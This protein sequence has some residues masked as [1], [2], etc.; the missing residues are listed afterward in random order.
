MADLFNK[1]FLGTL[2]K[3]ER[4]TPK[5]PNALYMINDG[6]TGVKSMY[7]GTQ[8]VSGDFII[9]ETAPTPT[10]TEKGVIY[11]IANFGV[12]Q[13][14]YVGF[15]DGN[16][17]VALSD[18]ATIAAIETRIIDLEN[19]TK[20][21]GTATTDSI[22]AKVAQL[23]GADTVAGSVK[24]QIHDAVDALDVTDTEVEG[25]VVVAVSEDNGKVSNIKKVVAV[26]K[27][28]TP[29]EGQQATYDVTIGTKSVGKIDIPFC[30]AVLKTAKLGKMDSEVDDNGNIVTPEGSIEDDALCL[31]FKKANGKYE[32]VKVNVS[33][34]LIES[35]FKNGL[36]VK[37]GEVSVKLVNGNDYLKFGEAAE[38]ENAPLVANVVKYAA[39]GG[40]A[41]VT[42]LADALDF[43]TVIEENK[44]VTATALTDIYRRIG[45]NEDLTTTAKVVV[46]AINELKGDI[47]DKN[48][49]AEG[50]D[51]VSAS[52][53]QNKVTVTATAST[54]AS[55]A[56]ADSAL[57]TVTG[58]TDADALISVT[59]KVEKA[60]AVSATTK[61]K[62]AVA[63]AEKAIQSVS[64]KEPG[65][66]VSVSTSGTAVTVDVKKAGYTPATD[67]KKTN[68]VLTETGLVDSTVLKKYVADQIAQNAVYWETL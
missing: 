17:W 25:S 24:K 41:N 6:A 28:K 30:D 50:D 52:A 46:D 11:Y 29:T 3:Y 45:D 10:E 16:K 35:E 23:D 13:K 51:Y 43:K 54:K 12:L 9:S 21:D 14:P 15:W 68:G 19:A 5:D 67:E 20:I 40:D 60:S 2:D 18:S 31:V 56:L 63:A 42:G 44:K 39:A 26:T 1:I 8:K 58:E 53:A 36:D 33:T 59:T 37:N 48:V 4:V 38:K 27:Q 62:N 49:S 47:A 32:L 65:Q 34:F 55:L 66:E 64:E 7:K 22:G 61:L 57:Q